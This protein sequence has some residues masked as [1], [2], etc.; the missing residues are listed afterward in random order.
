VVYTCMGVEVSFNP[1]RLW[2]AQLYLCAGVVDS[3]G[4]RCRSV[5]KKSELKQCHSGDYLKTRGL[6]V[7]D[8][9]AITRE[10]LSSLCHDTNIK[11]WRRHALT[12]IPPALWDSN[13]VDGQNPDQ[14]L[15]LMNTIFCSPWM[16]VSCHESVAFQNKITKLNCVCNIAIMYMSTF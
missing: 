3:S 9:Q 7:L 6:A 15:R 5:S 10:M 13:P 1:I 4:S 11:E 16:V 2:L 8:S 12:S 14:W